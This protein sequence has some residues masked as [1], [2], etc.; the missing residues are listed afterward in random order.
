MLKSQFLSFYKGTP[1][2]K[3]ASQCYDVIEKALY[4][5]G[6]LSRNTLIGALATVRVEVGKKYLP[7][8]EIASG[9]AYEGRASLG[10][11]QPG[12]GKR[13]KGRGYIQLTGRSN[14]TNYGKV[15]GID[16][17]NVPELALEVET[18]ARIFALYFKDR[19]CNIACNNG[20]WALVRKKVNGGSNGLSEFLKVVNQFISVTK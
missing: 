19:A 9:E 2:E 17:V 18:S 1:Y 7:I 16:L 4:E 11:T 10:N 6:I 20:D 3:G 14:Y 5:Q 13:Y 15:L 12:D 8:P